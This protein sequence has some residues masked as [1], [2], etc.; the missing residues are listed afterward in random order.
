M[1]TCVED[2]L[3]EIPGLVSDIVYTYMGKNKK[4]PRYDSVLK[5]VKEDMKHYGL[6]WNRL[7]ENER[8]E[9]DNMCRDAFY[10]IKE[11]GF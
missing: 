10:G 6:N 5:L 9:I 7:N 11:A 3:C 4:F 2:F 8:Y 1:I